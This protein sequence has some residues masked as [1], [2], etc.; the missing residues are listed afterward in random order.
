MGQ[1]LCFHYQNLYRVPDPGVISSR[2]SIS[3]VTVCYRAGGT[4]T[5][6][7][8]KAL[9]FYLDHPFRNATEVGTM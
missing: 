3:G 8:Y 6:L 1:P 4:P 2:D 5:S 9:K 7:S